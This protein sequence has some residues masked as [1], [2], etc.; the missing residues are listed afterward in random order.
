MSREWYVIHTYSGYENKVKA[1]LE[2]RVKSMGVD[3]KVFQ[4]LIPTQDVVQIKGGKKVVSKKKFFPGY[5]LVE[6]ETEESGK[7][8]DDSWDLV[9]NTPGVTGFVGSGVKPTP[10]PER[11]MT[12]I[13][14]QMK[15]TRAKPKPVALFEL[16]E[17]VKV[18]E[19][20]FNGFNGRV[21]EVNP[22]KGTLK[23][24]V[25]IFGRATPLNLGFLQVKKF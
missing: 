17:I 23:I 1:N 10:L 24:M 13:L 3:D 19:G 5:A 7:L 11:E 2:H 16:G 25:N 21:E 15:K 22:E 4:V 8:P 20:P 9:R 18:V 12:T 6:M 14:D